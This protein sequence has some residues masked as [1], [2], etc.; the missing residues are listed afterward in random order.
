[1]LKSSRI[2]DES[3]GHPTRRIT[4]NLLNFPRLI[5]SQISKIK[6]VSAHLLLETSRAAKLLMLSSILT[7]SRVN[8][9]REERSK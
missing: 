7:S 1:M 3:A 6:F 8:L 2:E 4:F 5:I 9:G